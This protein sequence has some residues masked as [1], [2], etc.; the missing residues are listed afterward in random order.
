M[1]GD[2]P[3][4]QSGSMTWS[5]VLVGKQT[6]G[7]ARADHEHKPRRSR[8]LALANENVDYNL[9][10]TTT[11]LSTAAATVSLSAT[12]LTVNYFWDTLYEIFSILV[13]LHRELHCLQCHQCSNVLRRNIQIVLK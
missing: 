10:T 1:E 3:S 13:E 2:S 6:P 12:V 5:D 8:I 4:V 7:C 9:T 11:V